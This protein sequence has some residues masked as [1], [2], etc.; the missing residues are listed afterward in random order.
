MKLKVLIYFTCY[1]LIKYSNIE[2]LKASVF[3]FVLIY[4]LYISFVAMFRNDK[5]KEEKKINEL[6]N[7]DTIILF[8]KYKQ[9]GEKRLNDLIE[10]NLIEKA[11][12]IE[13]K[14]RIKASHILISPLLYLF[15]NTYNYKI[16]LKD[17]E[18]LFVLLD[19]NNTIYLKKLE[20]IGY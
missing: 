2:K 14:R 10:N 11:E 17:G 7:G 12:R 20:K 4:S 18:V 1:L 13:E 15:K 3:L 19:K 16:K 8:G 9:I 5:K 6:E